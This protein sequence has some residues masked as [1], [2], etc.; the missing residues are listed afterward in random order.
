VRTL[1][2]GPKILVIKRRER[3]GADLSPRSPDRKTFSRVIERNP[4]AVADAR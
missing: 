4:L 2:H 1:Q 3:G